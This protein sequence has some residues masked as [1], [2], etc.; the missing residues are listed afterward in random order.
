MKST[1][2]QIKSFSLLPQVSQGE[3]MAALSRMATDEHRHIKLK[4]TDT[5]IISAH[6]IPR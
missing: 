3:E 5:V 4:P 2:T 6:A 1:D